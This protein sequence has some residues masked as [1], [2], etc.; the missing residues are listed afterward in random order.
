MAAKKDLPMLPASPVKNRPNCSWDG[1]LQKA[2]VFEEIEY[3][4]GRH[5]LCEFHWVKAH[6]LA[7]TRRC[8][9]KGLHTVE[10]KRD[11]CR[12][13]AGMLFKPMPQEPSK[14]TPIQH[15]EWVLSRAPKGSIGHRYALEALADLKGRAGLLPKQ[16]RDPGQDDEERAAA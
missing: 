14:R 10:Q 4:K 15:W 11:Y 13:I 12:K 9:E 6:A 3:G 7:A 1:C 5:H 8:E 16:Q 2:V